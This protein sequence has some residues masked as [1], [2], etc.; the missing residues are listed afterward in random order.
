[1]RKALPIKVGNRYGKLVVEITGLVKRTNKK[2]ASKSRRFNYC[3]CDCGNRIEVDNWNLVN[4]RTK[5]CGCGPK[6]AW[7]K[8]YFKKK[9]VPSKTLKG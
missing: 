3:L 4:G 2:D 1:M 8:L 7:G 6:Y 9:R 5:S